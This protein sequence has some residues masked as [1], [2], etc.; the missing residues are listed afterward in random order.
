MPRVLV[1]GDLHE[2]VAQP[3][4]H[5]IKLGHISRPEACQ[6]C[7]VTGPVHGH[8]YDYAKP[9]DVLWL[10]RKCHGITHRKE[11]GRCA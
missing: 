10:C 1:I 6:K 3:P 8:H 11:V 9:F 2:P 7:G 5:A 4:R